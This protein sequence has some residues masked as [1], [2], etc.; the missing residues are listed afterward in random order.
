MD[1]RAIV[2]ECREARMHIEAEDDSVLRIVSGAPRIGDAEELLR[3]YSAG[4]RA[5]LYEAGSRKSVI[6]A[7]KRDGEIVRWP[8][9]E[10]A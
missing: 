6:M 7:E 8:S 2:S 3:Y 5:R 9:E 4:K 1:E 10:I